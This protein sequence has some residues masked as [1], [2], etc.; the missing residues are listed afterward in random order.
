MALLDER[1]G[2][3]N[4]KTD[5]A[6]ADPVLPSDAAEMK[7]PALPAEPADPAEAD[8][9]RV[10]ASTQ[11]PAPSHTSGAKHWNTVILLH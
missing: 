10:E 4:E 5:E 1:K 9:D 6:L 7:D 2:M 11:L 8:E 3:E